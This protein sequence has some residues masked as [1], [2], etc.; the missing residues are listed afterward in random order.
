MI[1]SRLKPYLFIKVHL[2]ALLSVMRSLN[3]QLE[4]IISTCSHGVLKSQ[5]LSVCLSL[6]LSHTVYL[7]ICLSVYL[8]VC[9]VLR[10]LL[11]TN[12]CIVLYGS[13]VTF[14]YILLLN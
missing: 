9:C 7:S 11:G 5:S 13:Q 2:H 3:T 10:S 6:S 14:M 12:I 4:V 8:N 1:A